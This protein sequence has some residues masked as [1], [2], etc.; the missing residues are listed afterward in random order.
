MPSVKYNI[1][2][3]SIASTFQQF[4]KEVKAEL[5]QGVQRLAAQ[6]HAHLKETAASDAKMSSRTKKLYLD[7]LS[8]TTI[9]DGIHVVSLDQSAGWID[10]GIKSEYDMKP[11]LLKSPDGISK[12]GHAYKVIPL[13]KA[14][15]PSNSSPEDRQVTSQ[16]KQFLKK[17]NVK[18]SPGEHAP[19]K[20]NKFELNSDGSPRVGKVNSFDIPSKVPGKG[21]TPEL[22][23]LSIYQTKMPNGNIR[24][25]IL[26]FRTVSA[27]PN[28]DG[29]WI[30]PGFEGKKF[31]EGAEEWAQKTWE[32]DILPDIL[33]KWE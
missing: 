1:D 26:T 24:R 32:N 5:Q 6:T 33:K 8:F 19:T 9:G 21:N 11:S 7:G 31:F 28:S 22:F 25:D 20:T 23:G 16:V 4:A 29:K 18:Y 13:D 27:G 17:Q 10:D 12:D 14:K 3:A 2:I 30:H 15:G